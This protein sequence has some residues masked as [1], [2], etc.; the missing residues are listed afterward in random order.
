MS[1]RSSTLAQRIDSLRAAG[2]TSTLR[3]I[4]V[5]LE[6]EALR[7]NEQAHLSNRSHPSELGSALTHPYIT[8]DYSEALIELITPPGDLEATYQFL[9]DLHHYTYAHLD[10]EYLWCGSM[11]CVIAGDPD[12]PLAYYGE[13]NA[14][15]MKTIYRRGLGYR[16][17]RSMQVIA[18]V[19]FNCSMPK[20]FW[21]CELGDQ[22]S[23]ADISKRY[24]GV[25]R[26]FMR[27]SWLT[28][29]L[30]GASPAICRRF[31][32]Q[33]PSHYQLETFTPGTFYRPDATSLRL[34]ALAIKTMWRH[35]QE[36]VLNTT[37]FPNISKACTG[38]PARLVPSMSV[39]A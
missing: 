8:T 24:L 33:H 36:C 18:G 31:V 22:P 6:R 23:Q 1:L 19:H 32:L 13:S 12:I 25:V 38:R 34:G 28:A 21:D 37:I 39:L 16:Y 10:Q 27:C 7:V 29:Y 20:A 14:G 4:R 30:F 17:T 35:A 2:A 26:N 3:D 11:P 9:T 15:R 5:G